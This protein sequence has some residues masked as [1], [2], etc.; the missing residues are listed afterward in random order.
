ME[1]VAIIE[2]ADGE[3][4]M[5]PTHLCTKTYFDRNRTGE[6][7]TIRVPALFVK[8]LPQ[9]LLTTEQFLTNR[10]PL[11]TKHDH[12]KLRPA[13]APENALEYLPFRSSPFFKFLRSC[14]RSLDDNN[15]V[16]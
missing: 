12:F 15:C 13:R 4:D 16:L 11:E 5:K 9:D 1:K 3:E 6:F 7:V 8:G 2:T 14:L 10:Q